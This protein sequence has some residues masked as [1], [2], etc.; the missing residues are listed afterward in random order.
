MSTSAAAE[1]T[2]GFEE[3]FRAL[4]RDADRD[5]DAVVI[6]WP[7]VPVEIVW[8]AGLRAVAARGSAAPTQAADAVLEPELFPNRL[9]QLV[10]AALTG[11]LAHVA[12]IVLPRTSDPDYKCFL[13]L[14][15]LV[16][17]GAAP[18]LPP[19]LLFDLLHTDGA[20]AAA[21]DAARVQDLLQ[22]LADITGRRSEPAD[23]RSAI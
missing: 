18:A 17:R 3:P 7:S 20:D 21:Y 8:A 2:A 1:L 5:R 11:R 23:L 15:E 16:R 19:V 13:Y 14:R 6:S 22:R 4:G 12:A 10:E 9:H